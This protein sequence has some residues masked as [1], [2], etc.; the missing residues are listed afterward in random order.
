M[1]VEDVKRITELSKQEKWSYPKTFQALMEAG[2]TSYRTDVADHRTTYSGNDVDYVEDILS[3]PTTFEV[4]TSFHKDAVKRALEHH[5]KF[6][7]P[8][9]NFLKD[10]A[11]AGVNYYVV[12]MANR[13]ITYTSGKT[14][15]AFIQSIP[16]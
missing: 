3:S 14:D 12:D 4:S 16:K 7:T 10:I 15:E 13:A 8:Y 11:S 9:E 2:V 5:Q 1:N 6:N